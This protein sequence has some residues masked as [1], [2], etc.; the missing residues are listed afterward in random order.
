M[1]SCCDHSMDDDCLPLPS[2]M[3]TRATRAATAQRMTTGTAPLRLRP[4]PAAAR[5]VRQWPDAQQGRIH[6]LGAAQVAAGIPRALAKQQMSRSSICVCV[7]GKSVQCRWI[8]VSPRKGLSWSAQKS[9]HSS[10]AFGS[11]HTH[12]QT[13]VTD[14]TSGTSLDSPLQSVSGLGR[15]LRRPTA[16]RNSE[17]RGV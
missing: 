16:P 12:A 7:E 1:H 10:A 4:T 14:A 5:R 17:R 3:V 13:R 15:G 9:G 2:V 8:V 11:T 6:S